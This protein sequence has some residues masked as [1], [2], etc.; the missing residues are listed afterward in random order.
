MASN[1]KWPAISLQ[2]H[3]AGATAGSRLFRRV[4]GLHSDGTVLRRSQLT[5]VVELEAL[6]L[7]LE[8]KV[9]DMKIPPQAGQE[10]QGGRSGPN[11]A[12]I[13]NGSRPS[14]RSA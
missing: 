5:D 12:P 11:R 9:L 4:A 14:R 3:Y 1:H 8:S 13:G 6:S 7:A 2:D 10:R